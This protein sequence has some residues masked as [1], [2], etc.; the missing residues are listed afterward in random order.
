[1]ITAIEA[2]EAA[3]SSKGLSPKERQK[4][5]AIGVYY[6]YLENKNI[7]HKGMGSFVLECLW[8]RSQCIAKSLGHEIPNFDPEFI[9][10]ITANPKS[11]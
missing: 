5:L 3:E 6:F 11:N 4:V 1:M 9:L 8:K 10:D 2:I 7:Q